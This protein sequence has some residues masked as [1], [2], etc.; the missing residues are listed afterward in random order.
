[1]P[2]T[3]VAI[4]ADGA[5]LSAATLNGIND[6]SAFL[7]SLVSGVNVPFTTH[8]FTGSPSPEQSRPYVFRRQARY[9]HFRVD[10]TSNDTSDFDILIDG[11]S[12]Y[13]DPTNRSAAYSYTGYIDLTGIGSPPAVGDFY[14][15]VAEIDWDVGGTARVVYFLESDA[16]AL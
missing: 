6:N 11:V 5:V 8:S 3:P 14:E 1:M 15:V 7:Y 16:T 12:E 13:N 9:L 10:L 4:P 2:Y